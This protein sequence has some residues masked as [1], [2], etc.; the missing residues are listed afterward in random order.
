MNAH[1]N[2]TEGKKS[3]QY[4]IKCSSP[5]WR[6]TVAQNNQELLDEHWIS[7]KNSTQPFTSGNVHYRRRQTVVS[8]GRPWV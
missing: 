2:N 4:I 7:I 1:K 5:M 6:V 8:M 3:K